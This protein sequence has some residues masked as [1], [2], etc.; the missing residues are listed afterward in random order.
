[1]A[2]KVSPCGPCGIAKWIS[3]AFLLLA[4]IASVIGAYVAHFSVSGASFGTTT[5]SLSLIALVA[6]LTVFV[7]HM[8]ACCGCSCEK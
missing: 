7:K 6:S 4:A 8:Q 2:K 1:M 3:G 5:G